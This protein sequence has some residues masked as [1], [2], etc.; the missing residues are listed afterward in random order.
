MSFPG[1]KPATLRARESVTSSGVSVYSD[2]AVSVRARVQAARVRVQTAEGDS[3]WVD[4][5]MAYIDGLPSVRVGDKFEAAET[6]YEVVGVRAFA[7]GD[8][9]QYTQIWLDLMP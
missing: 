8:L 4:G 6:A 7:D 1:Q 5:A 3:D 2:T 9:P